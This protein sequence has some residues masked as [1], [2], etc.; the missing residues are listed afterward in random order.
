[1]YSTK[2]VYYN[3]LKGVISEINNTPDFP[4]LVI[5]VG[6]DNK[7]NVNICFKK[8]L[9]NEVIKDYKIGD[10]IAI[11]FF[12]TSRFKHDRWYTM[13]NALSLL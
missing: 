7:R 5:V 8:E 4:S 2:Q 9:L 11:N 10:F 13:C 1:M 3:Q 6:H 12:V